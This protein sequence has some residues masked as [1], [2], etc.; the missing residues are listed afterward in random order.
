MNFRGVI[1]YLGIYS[2]IVSLFLLLNFFYSIYF[3][4]QFGL[5][6]YLVSFFAVFTIGGLFIY[7]GFKN[8]LNL[9]YYDQLLLVL[10]GFFYIPFIMSFPFFL[11]GYELSLLNLYFESV[12]GF[13]STGF[14]IFHDLNYIDKSLLIWRSMLQWLGGIYFL[15][16]LFSILGTRRIMIKPTYLVFN[17]SFGGNYHNNF[18]S[19]SAKLFFIYFFTTLFIFISYILVDINF[20]DSFNLAITV[21]SSGGFLPVNFLE[22]IIKNNL[23]IIILSF[24]FLVP[25][26]NFFIFYNIILK[27]F[28]YK[29][30]F[31]DIYILF[32]IIVIIFLVYF[33][34][35]VDKNF[36]GIVLMV[37]SSISTIGINLKTQE[38][39]LFF[40]FILLTIV[41]GS[42]VSTSSG[43]KISRF[44]ILLKFSFNE[45]FKLV[46]P[47]NIFN[48]NMFTQEFK[49]NNND[50][51]NSFLIFIFFIIGIFFLSG[52]LSIET[53]PF[54]KSLKLSILTLTNTVNS[55]IFG[56]SDINF[57]SMTELSK[58]FLILFMILGK[59]ELVAFLV[60]IKKIIIKD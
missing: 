3:Q 42:S 19:N 44:Y 55:T 37:L 58:I 28:S 9:S 38:S 20:F 41:G 12:S 48:R 15:I 7:L 47:I 6:V 14:T 10:I 57:V 26:L 4:F 36:T 22:D 54:E 2:L 49:I 50:I 51:K 34:L 52:V 18:F 40:M 24:T 17:E 23:Q 21:V 8:K 25:I 60:L 45:M 56:L 29:N 5:K 32:L 46:K 27:R 59:V 1:Y 33:F 53:L 31:E 30:Y 39:N 35:S 16:S 13:T 11:S 43:F